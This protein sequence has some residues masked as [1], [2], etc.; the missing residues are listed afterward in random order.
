MSH[1][2]KSSRGPSKSYWIIFQHLLF[3][4]VIIH[5]MA[6][7][8]LGETCELSN[9]IGFAFTSTTKSWQDFLIS[10]VITRALQRQWSYRRSW[11]VNKSLLPVKSFKALSVFVSENVREKSHHEDRDAAS[12]DAQTTCL[13]ILTATNGNLTGAFHRKSITAWD[14]APVIA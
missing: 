11:S 14:E 7:R 1:F 13:E 2:L 6:L 3:H 10:V 5:T 12:N 4:P 8:G 9:L